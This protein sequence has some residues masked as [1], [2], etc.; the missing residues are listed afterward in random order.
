[1]KDFVTDLPR[2]RNSAAKIKK[3]STLLLRIRPEG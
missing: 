1:V 3:T 2:R